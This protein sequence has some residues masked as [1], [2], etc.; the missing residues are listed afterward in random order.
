MGLIEIWMKEKPTVPMK[1]KRESKIMHQISLY[2]TKNHISF[3]NL[4][5]KPWLK[6]IKERR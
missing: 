1:Y 6:L 5:G 3:K 2:V 4:F